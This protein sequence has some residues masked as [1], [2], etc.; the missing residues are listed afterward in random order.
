MNYLSTNLFNRGMVEVLNINFR[1]FY[2]LD[3]YLGSKCHFQHCIEHIIMDSF[4]GRGTHYIQLVKVL[5]C[6]LQTIG[7]KLPSVPH[8]VLGL[9]RRPQRWE[10][11]LSPLGHRG[12]YLC[13]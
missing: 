13:N 4:M 1:V 3:I 8:K 7:M 5:Y 2:V 6:E 9:N 10:A 12:P 11:S